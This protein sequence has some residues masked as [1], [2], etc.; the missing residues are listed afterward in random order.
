MDAHQFPHPNQKEIMT[1]LPEVTSTSAERLE[2]LKEAK[3]L[4]FAPTVES[5]T[6]FGSN[7]S[8]SAI[9]TPENL[10]RVAEYITTGHDYADTHPKGKR[11]PIIQ[12]V[13]VNAVGMPQEVAEK[14]ISDDFLDDLLR[15]GMGHEHSH[16]DAKPEADGKFGSS[17]SDFK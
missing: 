9:P 14:L 4:L 13:H 8:M 2:A 10:F 16:D 11:R 12:N 5:K 6:M 1:H 7:A 17:A 3:A 15:E